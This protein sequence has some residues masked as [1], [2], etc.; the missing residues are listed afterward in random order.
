MFLKNAEISEILNEQNPWWREGAGPDSVQAPST[1]RSLGRYLPGRLL[2]PRYRRYQV[3]LG[4][5]RVGKTTAMQQALQSLL[6]SGVYGKRVMW[7]SLDHPPLMDVDLGDFIRAAAGSAEATIEHPVFLF[8]DELIYAQHWDRWLK[9]AYDQAWPVQIIAGASDSAAMHKGRVESGIGRW[10]ELHLAPY[11]LGELLELCGVPVEI[12][13]APYLADTVER[14][15]QAPP[16]ASRLA[17]ERRRLLC[18]GGFPE[19]LVK[20]L[21]AASDEHGLDR[22]W[23]EKELKEAQRILRD[24]AIERAIHKDIPRSFRVDDPM[25]IERLLYTLAGQVTGILSPKNISAGLTDISKPT[26]NSYIDYLDQTYLVF[27]LPNYGG[28]EADVQR[29]GR[30]LYFVDG[31]VR[32]A[33]LQRGQRWLDDPAELG[34][35]QE[36]MVAAHLRTLAE[37]E[38]HRLYYWRRG[39]HEVDFV[40]DAPSEPLALEIGSSPK[41]SRSGMKAFLAENPQFHGRCYYVAPTLSFASARSAESGIGRMP[42]DWLLLAASLQSD[43]AL[44]ERMGVETPDR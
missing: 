23:E 22:G 38:R 20:S 35:L 26:L 12:G 14:I 6:G 29:R 17:L 42:L 16:S 27:T 44:R 4:P 41:H 10:Q 25:N 5:R 3:I 13:A 15:A 32:N 39:N 1:V 18:M 36:N 37:Q 21:G 31:A 30:K 11:L 33:V 34:V 28:K 40:Y 24:D 8:L 9:T 43:R 2:A 19:I 7:V